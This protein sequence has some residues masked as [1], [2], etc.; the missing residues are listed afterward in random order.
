MLHPRPIALLLTVTASL[1]AAGVPALA[2]PEWWQGTPPAMPDAGLFLPSP[3]TMPGGLAGITYPPLL[4]PALVAGATE[5]EW[6][7]TIE[8]GVLDRLEVYAAV[9]DGEDIVVAGSTG[10]PVGW[11][12]KL[13]GDGTVL[14]RHHTDPEVAY[15]DLAVAPGG[16]VYVSGWQGVDGQVKAIVRE[17]DRAGNVVWTTHIGSS[18]GV[19]GANSIDLDAAGNLHLLG[20]AGRFPMLAVVAPDGSVVRTQE[21]Q[22][23]FTSEY[24]FGARLPDGDYIVQTGQRLYRVDPQGAVERFS[25][26]YSPPGEPYVSELRVAPDGNIVLSGSTWEIPTP[27]PWDQHR[28]YVMKITPDLEVVW[29]SYLSAA[30]RTGGGAFVFAPDGDIVL[31]GA[32][33]WYTEYLPNEILGDYHVAQVVARFAPDG[34]ARFVR[35]IQDAQDPSARVTGYE[36]VLTPDGD[37]VALGTRGPSVSSDMF[38]SRSLGQSPLGPVTGPPNTL[39]NGLHTE[40]A[41]TAWSLPPWG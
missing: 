20:D 32:A 39:V 19:F 1:A 16:G 6:Q 2:A 4:A 23:I 22:D 27:I 31:V 11:V 34:T 40:V 37:I 3:V 36:P 38:V 28:A 18:T 17:L 24:A 5:T 10:Q 7:H 9:H 41:E 35:V 33:G 13:D 15:R 26:V 8:R 14:Y 29:A 21:F 30:E 25:L 12:Y